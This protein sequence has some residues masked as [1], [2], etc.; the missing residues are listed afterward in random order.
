MAHKDMARLLTLLIRLSHHFHL[1]PALEIHRSRL[2]LICECLCE[3]KFITF[4][5]DQRAAASD[6]GWWGER[7]VVDGLAIGYLLFR[8]EDEN[9]MISAPKLKINGSE[10]VRKG[11]GR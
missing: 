2:K 4:G 7:E 11:E 9:L 3:I 6:D 10:R 1:L 8:S 5:Y